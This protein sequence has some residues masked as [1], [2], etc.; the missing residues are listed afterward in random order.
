[1]L[2]IEFLMWYKH[3]TLEAPGLGLIPLLQDYYY[4]PRVSGEEIAP[5]VLSVR[6]LSLGILPQ[7]TST[8]QGWKKKKPY[9]ELVPRP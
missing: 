6:T 2:P 4:V 1:M 8:G 5:G 9:T 3:V 7:G